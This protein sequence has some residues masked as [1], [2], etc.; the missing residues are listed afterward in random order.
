YIG[1]LSGLNTVVQL[2]APAGFRARV[3]SLYLMALGVIYPLGALAQGAVADVTSLTEATVIAALTMLTVIGA[4]AL[5][6]PETL[7]A[8]G[9]APA[10]PAEVQASAVPTDPGLAG[11]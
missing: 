2:R 9:D 10:E 6:R 8:L 4:L 3:L 11:Q 5:F 7:R 1:I